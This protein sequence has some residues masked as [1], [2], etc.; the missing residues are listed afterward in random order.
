MNKIWTLL[1]LALAIEFSAQAVTP[2]AISSATAGSGRAAVEASESPFL[3]PAT[4]P[5]LR[6]YY[7]TSSYNTSSSKASDLTFSLTDHMPDTVVPTS[8][9]YSQS[10][11][12]IVGGGTL[13]SQDLR[14]AMAEKISEHLG[15]G[16]AIHHKSDR[17]DFDSYAQNNLIL[18]NVISVTD[19]LSFGLVFDDVLPAN[20]NV[21]EALRLFNHTS[22]GVSYNYK[23]VIRAKFDLISATNNS[24]SKPTA[25]GGVESFMNRW[26]VLRVGVGRNQETSSNILSAGL[27]FQGPKFGVHYAYFQNAEEENLA[28]HTVDLSI[29]VW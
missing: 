5:Y 7:F 2:G 19:D 26:L 22:A 25:V 21:P 28:R 27:G 6:G 10:T 9:G 14:L 8:L 29:P 17:N 4:L 18:A 16:F 1:C 12:P 11:T 15:V 24:F 3:N 23:R 20:A 13:R